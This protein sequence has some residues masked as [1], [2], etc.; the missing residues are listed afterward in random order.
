MRTVC[1]AMDIGGKYIK[2]ALVDPN[3]HLLDGWQAVPVNSRDA[4]QEILASFCGAIKR[5][6]ALARGHGC[7][8]R[9]ICVAMCG[10]LDYEKGVSLM[11]E[12]KYRSIYKVNL[13][14]EFHRAWPEGAE[15]DIKFIHDVQ[16][17][18]CGAAAL[19]P[20]LQSGRAMAVTL[21]TG[22]GSA[23]MADGTIIPPGDGVP[24]KG[25]GRMPFRGGKLENFI[26]GPALED[27][28]LVMLRDKIRNRNKGDCYAL[29]APPAD[30]RINHCAG[31]E[32]ER[33]TVKE[34]AGLARS[35]DLDACKVF[36]TLGDLLGEALAPPLR[37][38]QPDHLV[39][40]GQISRAFDL[41]RAPL[42]ARISGLIPESG[43]V[44]ADRLESAAL[45]GAVV[46]AE[47]GPGPRASLVR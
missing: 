5:G 2:S 14:H 21:G 33:L 28:Y 36:Q 18:L 44:R 46:A 12:D 15:A 23:F 43:I 11:R 31:F 22:V 7:A 47:S 40:G 26:G 27:L 29:A 16:A 42:M 37:D 45:L 13:K 25:L 10:P 4:A 6:L 9:R 1:F 19:D 32:I 38:F 34:I 20:A 8:V 30:P 39:F 17:F 3:R 41:L 35:G 24:D